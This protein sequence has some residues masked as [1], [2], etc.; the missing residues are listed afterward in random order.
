VSSEAQGLTDEG[1]AHLRELLRKNEFALYC[2]PIRALR[3]SALAPMAEVLVRMREEEKALLPPGE[4]LPA[5][6]HYGMMPQLDSWVLRELVA[7]HARRAPARIYC[8]NVSGQTLEFAGFAK[9]FAELVKAAGVR[10]DGFLFEIE[11]NEV[12]ARQQAAARFAGELRALGAGIVIE[13][14]GRESGSFA[15]AKALRP[16]HLKVDGGIVR[17]IAAHEPSLR[18]L[19]AILRFAESSRIGVIAECVE[20][21]AVLA[22]L[23]ALGVGHAQGFGIS[24]PAPIENLPARAAPGPVRTAAL[25]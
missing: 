8:V 7:K 4:F 14:F 17:K 16:A 24:H 2:Q 1:P 15:P 25:A 23:E 19:E 21:P 6:E 3:A 10:P 12:L 13:S 5:F 11:E 20:E 18:K 22:R 9:L